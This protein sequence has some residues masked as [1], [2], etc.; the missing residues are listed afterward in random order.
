MSSCSRC[1]NGTYSAADRGD[2][3]VASAGRYSDGITTHACQAGTYSL[4][5]SS[6]CEPCKDGH[7]S[8]HESPQ[9]DSSRPGRFANNGVDEVP[10]DAGTFLAVSVRSNVNTFM[11]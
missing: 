2:C 7:F 1:E 4:A 8:G 10:C 11:V 5:R 6:A 9:C 3:L